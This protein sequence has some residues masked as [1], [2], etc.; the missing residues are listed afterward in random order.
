MISHREA[1]RRAADAVW[2]RVPSKPSARDELHAN[3]VYALLRGRIDGKSLD[4]FG[5]ALVIVCALLLSGRT[6]Y[7]TLSEDHAYESHPL[8]SPPRDGDGRGREEGI[9]GAPPAASASAS[10][11][12]GY[13]TCEIAVPGNTKAARERRGREIGE[14]FSSDGSSSSSKPHRW[15]GGSGTGRLTA[16]TSWLYMASN[17]IVCRTVPLAIAAAVANVN[18]HIETL[19]GKN[20][21][22]GPLYDIKGE[23]LWALYDGGFLDGFPYALA[24]LGECEENRGEGRGCDWVDAGPGPPGLGVGV[25]EERGEEK[26][27]LMNERL[28]LD[29]IR[30]S[31]E[32]YGDQQVYPYCYA[33]HYHKDAGNLQLSSSD[34]GSEEWEREYRLVEAVRLYSQAAG[35]MSR[36]PFEPGD[37]MQ[38]VKTS[39][40]LALL[41][42]DDVLSAPEGDDDEDRVSGGAG[43]RRNGRKRSPRHWRRRE[44]AV[45]AATWLLAFFDHLLLWEERSGEVIGGGADAAVVPSTAGRR[46]VEILSPGHRH[47]FG[48]LFELFEWDVRKEMASIVYDTGKRL[49]IVRSS[50]S[51][52]WIDAITHK[53]LRYY[54]STKSQRLL[55]KDRPL[56]LALLRSKISVGDLELAIPGPEN[57]N[58]RRRSKRSIMD[59]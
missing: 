48:K 40:R 5:S 54:Q 3:G 14:T 6:S 53:E 11:I 8:S 21:S 36:Y 28:Y 19:G 30:V 37:S 12:D 51:D 10:G 44:D 33:G 56:M 4:C 29:A 23:L 58:R 13:G 49:E 2:L 16:H 32:R 26:R 15:G 34:G 1:V 31:R 25:R 46:F 50:P 27:I 24:E 42:Y 9:E 22:S 55:S 47:S 35:V 17:P 38:L 7:L 43:C 59:L 20:V 18:C 45:A 41:L 57:G 39:T 52:P